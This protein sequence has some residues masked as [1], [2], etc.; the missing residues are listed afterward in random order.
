M[1]RVRAVALLVVGCA[2]A[3]AAASTGPFLERD[4]EVPPFA[5][6]RRRVDLRL[7]RP[8]RRAPGEGVANDVVA[9]FDVVFRGVVL[10]V[11]VG[12]LLWGAY[13]LVRT[14]A[15]LARLR[16]GPPAATTGTD[17]FDRGEESR[18]DAETALRRR[19]ADELRLL[20][21]DLD[22]EA[23]P[24]EAVIACYVRMEAALAEAGTPRA[25]T[26]TPLELL[27][28]VLDEYDVP[29]AD[30]RRLTDLFTEARFSPHPVTDEMRRAA[31]RSLGAVSDALAVRS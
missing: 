18:E 3:A 24:R 4:R 15:R 25:A 21:A 23:E 27:R 11:V 20:S 17:P 2:L 19:V 30:V 1:T 13:R 8:R 31:R 22:T 5:G 14:L 10:A 12:V 6:L 9:V 7:P 29:A 26:E 16:L 28:R